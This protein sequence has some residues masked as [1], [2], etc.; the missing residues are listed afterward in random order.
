MSLLSL[1]FFGCLAEKK[2]ELHCQETTR[3]KEREKKWKKER[4]KEKND[5]KGDRKKGRRAE[6]KHGLVAGAY[7]SSQ[8]T[9]YWRKVLN[10][11]VGFGSQVDSASKTKR[12]S[13]KKKERMISK[14]ELTEFSDGYGL[15]KV[16]LSE[17]P[18]IPSTVTVVLPFS[19]AAVYQAA[20]VRL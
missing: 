11:C 7:H 1:S 18:Q 20:T 3:Q 2:M 9:I 13:L 16:L 15:K 5:R 17:S 8:A 14:D 19:G 4:K 6:E 10:T 12:L